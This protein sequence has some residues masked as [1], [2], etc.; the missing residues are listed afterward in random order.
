V[1]GREPGGGLLRVRIGSG[2]LQ[3]NAASP[4]GATLRVQMLARDIIVATRKPEFLSVTQS[5]KGIVTAVEDD[6]AS[7]LISIDVGGGGGGDGSGRRFWRGSPRR[8]PASSRSR[9]QNPFGPW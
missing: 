7:D 5:L 9:P 2:E 6:G 3:V 4:A 1:L 8:P